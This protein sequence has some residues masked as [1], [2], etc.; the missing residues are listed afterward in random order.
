[1]GLRALR[2]DWGG[3]ALQPGFD[4]VEPEIDVGDQFVKTATDPVYAVLDFL[5][6]AGQLPHLGFQ[7]AHPNFGP[8]QTWTRLRRLR[9]CRSGPRFGRS[10]APVIGSLQILQILF[11]TVQ[12]LQQLPG[13]RTLRPYRP[14]DGAQGGKHDGEEKR[15]SAVHLCSEN[16][17]FTNYLFWR[18]KGS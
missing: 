6:A 4:L 7:L 10:L 16:H 5:D 12:T 3:F 11:Q 8:G 13:L 18:S 15:E 9:G 14:L 1:L 2:R 17:R